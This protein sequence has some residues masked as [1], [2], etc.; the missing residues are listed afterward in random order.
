M[1]QLEVLPGQTVVDGQDA[2]GDFQTEGQ[3]VRVGR[4]GK[5]VVGA[6]AEPLEPVL[7]PVA[8]G[9]Q[10]DVGVAVAAGRCGSGGRARGR[11]GGAS[12]SRRSEWVSRLRGRSAR[13]PRR[14]GRQRL[15]G[16]VFSSIRRRNRAAGGWSSAMRI[17]IAMT[18][19]YVNC[20]SAIRNSLPLG[21][22]ACRLGRG[23]AQLSTACRVLQR[24]TR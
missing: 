8:R 14:Q 22:D 11:R 19:Q 1:C 2:L 7:A 17:F 23:R 21:P 5:E 20:S 6:G 16:P 24:R 12:S 3:L 10:D 15:R 18:W 13:P 9:E 4:L